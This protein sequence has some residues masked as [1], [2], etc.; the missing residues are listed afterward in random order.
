MGEKLSEYYVKTQAG[1]KMMRRKE[2]M[3]TGK[4]EME[5]TLLSDV[6]YPFVILK[7]PNH[8]S[9]RA[10]KNKPKVLNTISEKYPLIFCIPVTNIPR[11]TS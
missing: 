5:L 11:N 10:E 3:Q 2:G 9:Q 4:E 8:I 1:M 7:W 6:T